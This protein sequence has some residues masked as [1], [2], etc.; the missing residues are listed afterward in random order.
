MSESPG[1]DEV[2]RK[3]DAGSSAWLDI[4]PSEEHDRFVGRVKQAV[5]IYLNLVSP[6]ELRD[7]LEAFEKA[8]R[9]PSAPISQLV[10]GLSAD[11]QD[12]LPHSRPLPLPP[13]NPSTSDAYY[14]DI[15]SHLLRGQRWT[16]KGVHAAS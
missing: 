11:A 5:Q 12:M 3:I 6:K 4:I 16:P 14:N 10:P 8:T 2:I 13:D 1:A 15:R 9:S 7:E